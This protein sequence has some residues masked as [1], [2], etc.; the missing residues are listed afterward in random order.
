[1]R[2]HRNAAL[3]LAGRRKL[4]GLIEDGHSLKA[5]AAALSVSPATAHRWWTR[6]MGADASARRSLGCLLDRSSRPH[7]SPRLLSALE[8]ARICRA[9]K[10][11][12]L[13]PGRLAGVLGRARS[14]IWKVLRRAGRS[15]LPR[16]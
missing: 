5:A 8:Q 14:T 3:G 2:L 15:R 16:A 6:W 13:G 12:N 7:R 4:V 11:T 1:M 9:R 10:L